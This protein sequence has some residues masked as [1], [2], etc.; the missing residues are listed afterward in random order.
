MI[1]NKCIT[2]NIDFT[3]PHNPSRKY[4]YCSLKCMG[5]DINKSKKHSLF[6]QAHSG[7]NKGKKFPSITGKNHYNWTGGKYS[8]NH[9]DRGRFR[10][11]VG[12]EVLKR[13]NYTCLMC[14]KKGGYLHVDHV[15]S[16][17]EYVE[18]RFN[19]DNCQTLCQKCHYLITFKKQISKGN[20]WGILVKSGS[21]MEIKKL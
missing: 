13:D 11:T 18:L 10:D 14:G 4:R 5:K 16:W 19:I 2:C 7:W 17:S 20:R 15:Q 1:K 21:K 12:K 3:K 6:M 8:Q 9:R